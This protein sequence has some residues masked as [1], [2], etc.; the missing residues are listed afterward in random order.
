MQDRIPLPQSYN[1]NLLILKNLLS[2]VS[3]QNNLLIQ[4]K[5]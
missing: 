3:I 5:T 2:V 1:N 4:I